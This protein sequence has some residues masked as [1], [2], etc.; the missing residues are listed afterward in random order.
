MIEVP[1]ENTVAQEIARI[2]REE[3]K[4]AAYQAADRALRWYNAAWCASIGERAA[5]VY[6]AADGR[7]HPV[8]GPEGYLWSL[9][10]MMIMALAL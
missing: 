3:G 6:R 1:N 9:H 8:V 2:A 4:Y 5:L 10:G 7:V